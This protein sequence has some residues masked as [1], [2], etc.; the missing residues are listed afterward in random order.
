MSRVVVGLT[1]A[2]VTASFSGC[3]GFGEEKADPSKNA[4]QQQ[5][6]G[7]VLSTPGEPPV[8]SLNVTIDGNATESN[9]TTGVI[10]AKV[11][12]N[13]TFD[14]SASTGSNLTF[15][16]DFGDGT[17]VGTIPAPP[18]SDNESAGEA[19]STTNET[20]NATLMMP[21]LRLDGLFF[22]ANETNATTPS[23]N[24]TTAAPENV[25]VQHAYN[26]TGTF[27]VT[28]YV[29][30]EWGQTSTA[31]VTLEVASAGPPPGTFLRE[32]KPAMGDAPGGTYLIAA[33]GTTCYAAF[34]K[35]LVIVDVEE[36]GTKSAAKQVKV[37]IA[38][39]GG[40]SN[41]A[42]MKLALKD[43][44][45]AVVKKDEAAGTNAKTLTV[46]GPL[47]AGTYK[48]EAQKCTSTLAANTPVSAVT[49]TVVYVAA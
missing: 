43:P 40:S 3:F 48:V 37:S 7:S 1:L 41:G 22:Q 26:A 30:D 10:S 18:A 44:A 38:A 9:A 23:E 11:G 27:N 17:T 46:D 4:A 33:T 42:Y 47:A 13:L 29:T 31:T 8:A 15:A 36:N 25:V 35:D 32:D 12:V 14:G 21:V 34:T 49:A 20:G 5:D 6:Q 28:L 16:W 2:L 45:G 24:A 19:N 39:Y